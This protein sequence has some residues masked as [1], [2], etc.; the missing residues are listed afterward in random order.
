[1]VVVVM[2]RPVWILCLLLPKSCRQRSKGSVVGKWRSGWRMTESAGPIAPE[3]G[4][5]PGVVELSV[6]TLQSAQPDGIDAGVQHFSCL[7]FS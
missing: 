4:E 7:R 2:V 1:M 3:A 5:G 6:V